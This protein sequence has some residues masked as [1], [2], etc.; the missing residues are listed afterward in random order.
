MAGD[1]TSQA[2]GRLV[3]RAIELER[4]SFDGPPVTDTGGRLPTKGG[5]RL[6]S[7]SGDAG[8]A[9]PDSREAVRS[10][11]HLRWFSRCEDSTP[12]RRCDG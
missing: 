2:F 8:V 1:A 5:A 10:A 4:G 12:L 9:T 7:R 6:C 3:G 11:T